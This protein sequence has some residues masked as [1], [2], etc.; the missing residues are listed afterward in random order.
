M[1]FYQWHVR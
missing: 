1:P